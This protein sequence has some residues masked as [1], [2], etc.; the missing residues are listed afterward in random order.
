MAVTSLQRAT[1]YELED[2]PARLL[3]ELDAAATLDCVAERKSRRFGCLFAVTVVGLV[4][5]GF[6]ALIVAP[7]LLVGVVPLL[8]AA[9]VFG[10]RRGHWRRYDLDERKLG[11]V[12]RVLRM[13][14]VD[15]DPAR[16]V[17]LELDLRGYQEGGERVEGPPDGPRYVNQVRRYRYHHEW[18]HLS[19]RLLD[20]NAFSVRLQE[21]IARTEKSKRKGKKIKER[22]RGEITVQLRVDPRRYPKAKRAVALLRRLGGPGEIG[23]RSARFHRKRLTVVLR[24]PTATRVSGLLRQNIGLQHIP[25]G[26]TVLLSLLWVY[27]AM[28]ATTHTAPTPA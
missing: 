26:T 10:L 15:V 23:L 4:G 11:V 18:L 25:D 6:A 13:L 14:L 28:A 20:G 2:L 17:H 21:Q 27:R 5:L 12:R 1:R 19:G 7:Q 24:T 3:A 22:M 9:V 8:V 16:P